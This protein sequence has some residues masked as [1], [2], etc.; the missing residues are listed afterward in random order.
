VTDYRIK[1]M[2]QQ[3][4]RLLVETKTHYMFGAAMALQILFCSSM[5]SESRIDYCQHHLRRAYETASI[6]SIFIATATQNTKEK[7]DVDQCSTC[8]DRVS[9][10]CKGGVTPGAHIL[11]CVN[12]YVAPIRFSATSGNRSS[13]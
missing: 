2:L 3:L 7:L 11:F 12:L 9:I 6:F 5:G 10:A 8:D 4:Q 13:S 1:D